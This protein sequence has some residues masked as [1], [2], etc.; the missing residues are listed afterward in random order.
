MNI[1]IKF[2]ISVIALALTASDDL[3]AKERYVGRIVGTIGG[4]V[5]GVFAGYL[6]SDDDAIE[7]TK[8]LTR[9]AAL[10]GAAGGVGGYFLGRAVDKQ[11]SYDNRPD[12]V[13]IRQAQARAV[14]AV[15]KESVRFQ[16][17]PETPLPNAESILPVKKIVLKPEEL[18]RSQSP[19]FRAVG[20]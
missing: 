13:R 16:A 10:L 9:N 20:F 14:D 12:P 11:F 18:D 15:V 17:R 4:A 2:A 7:A 5:L 1:R 6:V 19:D 3:L 8:K